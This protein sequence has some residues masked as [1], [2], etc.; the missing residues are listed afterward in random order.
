MNFFIADFDRV[1]RLSIVDCLKNGEDIV[2]ER[3]VC[4]SVFNFSSLGRERQRQRSTLL[5]C[6]CI[7]QGCHSERL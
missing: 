3:R 5:G 1:F 4:C 7:F 6:T 2:G